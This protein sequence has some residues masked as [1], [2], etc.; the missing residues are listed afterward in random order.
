MEHKSSSKDNV[1][2]D[3]E[4]YGLL[5]TKEAFDAPR[6]SISNW[7]SA[8]QFFEDQGFV[9]LQ[10]A[11]S[12]PMMDEI[13][14]NVRSL[15]EQQVQK[16]IE[17]NA[18][19]K[20]NYGF[21]RGVQELANLNDIYRQRLYELIQNLPAL[22]KVATNSVFLDLMQRLGI[23]LPAISAQIRM[24][25]PG[26]K[27]FLI[28]PHQEISG[29]KSTNFRFM[30]LALE[31]TP[32]ISGALTAAP[33]SHKL[34]PVVP[35]AYEALRYQYVPPES[36]I[37]EHPLKQIPLRAGECLV[38]HKLLIHGST[39]NK[40]DTIRWSSIFRCEDMANMPYLDGD[41][42]YKKFALKV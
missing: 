5:E 31:D 8:H 18:S 15:I 39:E 11:I 21:D 23:S 19:F 33:G 3:I 40:S 9:I 34:G 36:Y 22:Y 30:I 20:P 1:M 13:K 16:H 38:L 25:M 17:P 35:R 37:H 24:D 26:D 7:S 4:E 42:S 27:R 41:D 12:A 28:P 14:A 6:F 29:I 10:D 32:T 2:F